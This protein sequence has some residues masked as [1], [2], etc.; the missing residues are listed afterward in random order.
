M[1]IDN[2]TLAILACPNCKGKLEWHEKSAVLVCR[3]EQ[4]AFPVRDGIPVL[5]VDEASHL[6]SEQLEAL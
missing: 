5:I 2:T 4:L 6:T 3:G 1:A